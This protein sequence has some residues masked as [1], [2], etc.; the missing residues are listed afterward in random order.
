[1]NIAAI[2]L[3][4]WFGL[5]LLI[6]AYYHGKEKTGTYN[7]WGYLLGLTIEL[8]VILWAIGWSLA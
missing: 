2:I 6:M 1:M 8:V 3:L 5:G 7:F 4:V